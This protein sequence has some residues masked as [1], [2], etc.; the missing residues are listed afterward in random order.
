MEVKDVKQKISEIDKK[1][2]KNWNEVSLTIF[3]SYNI[4]TKV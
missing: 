3:C 1:P 2:S 4:P